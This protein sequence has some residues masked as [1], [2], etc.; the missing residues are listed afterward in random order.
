MQKRSLPLAVLSITVFL[1]AGCNFTAAPQQR[2][3]SCPAVGKLPNLKLEHLSRDARGYLTKYSLPNSDADAFC[4]YLE[5]IQH[6][7]EV[8]VEDGLLDMM[9]DYF[10]TTQKI[11]TG[12]YFTYKIGFPDREIPKIILD[13]ASSESEQ[14]DL[15]LKAIDSDPDSARKAVFEKQLKDLSPSNRK[16]GA[17]KLIQLL[18]KK[19]WV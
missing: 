6:D 7:H 17:L 16:E 3:P 10:L 5:S 11:E 13:R 1:Y 19:S 14:A 9:G 12:Y 15:F 4:R 8:K 18:F 2:D